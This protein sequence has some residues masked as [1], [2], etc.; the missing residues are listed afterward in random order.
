[1]DR[2]SIESLQKGLCSVNIE[3][4]EMNFLPAGSKIDVFKIEKIKDLKK[5]TEPSIPVLMKKIKG[6]FEGGV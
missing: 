1:M 2:G 4:E 3:D 5:I 6:N